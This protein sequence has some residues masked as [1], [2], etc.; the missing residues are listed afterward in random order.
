MALR[1]C[2]RCGLLDELPRNHEYRGVTKDGG[3][4]TDEGGFITAE[5]FVRAARQMDVPPTPEQTAAWAEMQDQSW[6]T[7]HLNEDC[8]TAGPEGASSAGTGA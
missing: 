5:V 2:D 1:F 4:I 8:A 3:V 6:I 7:T